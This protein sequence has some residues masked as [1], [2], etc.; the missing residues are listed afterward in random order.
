MNNLLLLRHSQSKWNAER[1]FTGWADIDLTSHGKSEAELAGKLIK[2]LNIEFDLYF[3]SQLKRAVNTL[4]I[5][6]EKFFLLK[7][8]WHGEITLSFLLVVQIAD[9]HV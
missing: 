4:E 7:E 9:E 2:E 6:F 5:I 1:R 3:T 8:L